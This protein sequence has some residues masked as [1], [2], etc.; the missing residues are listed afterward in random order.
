[1]RLLNRK[2]QPLATGMQAKAGDALEAL[3][4]LLFAAFRVRATDIHI[5]PRPEIYSIRFRIDGLLHAV[6]EI[7]AKMGVAILNNIKLLGEAAM[8][9]R[10]TAQEA[11]SP[12]EL[13]TRR[14]DF[15]VNLTPT[16]HGQKLALRFLDKG[17]V[18]SQ[19]ENLGMEL[20]VVAELNRICGQDSGM[21]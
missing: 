6:G 2:S 3:R 13:P 20:D 7:T 8:P 12:P 14:V 21:I 16:V 5:E 4:Q 11:T 9:K 19:F 17:A 10:T 15:R 1:V 18:P